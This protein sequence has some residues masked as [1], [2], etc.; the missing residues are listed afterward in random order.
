MKDAC[1]CCGVVDADVRD[2]RIFRAT[3]HKL[4]QENMVRVYRL[5]RECSTAFLDH[6]DNWMQARRSRVE[7]DIGHPIEWESDK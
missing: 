4:E 6:S 1:Q 3:P 5:C 7:R 2:Y